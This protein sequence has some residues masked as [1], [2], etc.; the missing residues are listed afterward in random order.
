M[1]TT[2]QPLSFP[3]SGTRLIE[4]SAGTGKTYTIAALY[5]RL[6]LGH[7][8]DHS[9]P[10]GGL[11]PPEILV[12]T[13]TNAATEELRDRIRKRLVEGARCFRGQLAE[14]DPFLTG[15]RDSYPVDAH[16]GCALKLE[17]AAQMMDLSAIHTIHSWC[18]RMLREHAFDSGSLF[19]LELQT[20]L[21]GLRQEAVRDYWR[22][23]FYPM[24]S[25]ALQP[26]YDLYSTPA[27]LEKAL[28]PLLGRGLKGR[29]P[30]EVVEQ[31][32]QAVAHAKTV[33]R[34]EFET[35]SEQI[36]AALAAKLVS[37]AKIKPVLLEEV[38]RWLED[39]RLSLPQTA[40][41][42]PSKACEHFSREGIQAACNKGKSLEPNPAFEAMQGL[43]DTLASLDLKRNLLSHAAA[44]VSDRLE[45]EKQRQAVLGFDD[46]MRHL[47]GALSGDNGPALAQLIRQQFPAALIDEFQDTDPVQYRLFQTLYLDQP[48]CALMMIGDPKQAIYAFRGAD[49]HTYLQARRDT[50]GRH[51]T[52]GTNYRSTA[53]MVAAAN[54][55][56]ELAQGYPQ[57]PFLFADEIPF[58]S[59]EANGKS[60]RLLIDGEEVNGLNLW[61]DPDSEP[62]NK[63]RYLERQAE[64][65]ASEMCRFLT[66]SAQGRAGF[67]RNGTL[68]PLNAADMAILVRDF[69]EAKA[70]RTAL[71]RRGIRS[72]Y[73]SDK[74][75]VYASAE[76][77]DLLLILQAVVAP[78]QERRIRA[79][80]ACLTL[81]MDWATLDRLN[82]DE[83]QWDNLVEQ[84]RGY[85]QHWHNK[86]VLSMVRR[87]MA[88]YGIANRLMH[89]GGGERSLTNLLHLAEL[90][91]A[92]SA[93]VDG[94][95]ALLRLLAE[96]IESGQ[97]DD[98][99]ILRLESDAELVQVVTIH[100][101]KGLEYPLVLLPFVFGFRQAAARDGLLTYRDRDGHNAVAFNPE[102]QAIE[103]AEHERLAEDLR[104]LYVALTRP[105][106]ACFLGLAPVKLGRTGKRDSSDL[107]HSAL[108]YLLG[109][110]EPMDAHDLAARLQELVCPG[111]T[112]L[113][114]LPAVTEMLWQEASVDADTLCARTPKRRVPSGWRV[115]SYSALLHGMSHHRDG[116]DTDAGGAQSRIG[117][118]MAEQDVS[119]PQEP[120]PDSIH[121]FPRGA[122]PGTFLHDWLEWIANQGFDRYS[123]DALSQELQQRCDHKGYESWPPVLQPWV[124]SALAQPMRLPA[125]AEQSQQVALCQLGS[126][127]AEMEFWFA[128][129]DLDVARLDRLVREHLWPGLPRPTL[130][131]QQ[132]HGM[133][134]GFIDLTF[135]H[136]GRFYVADYKSNYLG[137]DDSAYCFEAMQEA[138]LSHRYDLQLALY[139]LALHRLL[140]TRMADYDYQRHLGGGVYLFLRGM[141]AAEADSGN[142]VIALKPDQAL[143]DAM[144][145]L[146]HG[147]TA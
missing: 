77:Q 49:I 22:G 83:H 115:G 112:L 38:R 91:Q 120:E 29:P 70:I 138:M 101:S 139:T 69:T 73:L 93:T 141:G 18:Q 9:H 80:L 39:D 117:E 72:V 114:P 3:L 5:L 66:L 122:G 67:E 65:A 4:A 89:E 102:P 75:S 33:W 92:A 82:G 42:K 113:S 10:S 8:G 118:L 12:V 71:D 145:A 53:G 132:L 2:L 48:H 21:S 109:Q 34:R 41:G 57:G 129:D 58:I 85:Q 94:E 28:M 79:A 68:T 62:V 76:A 144:D 86:G 125:G 142:G 136:Q 27:A 106:Y 140:K 61:L 63:G 32:C 30:A 74:D 56:F 90:M 135:E 44:W 143:V 20:D 88:D 104:L 54:S 43:V 137:P 131:P 17:L 31:Q 1:T 110:G 52:L 59:V 37:K 45:A 96:Q 124:T 121:A 147:E 78:E 13:F 127:V 24:T 133:L 100:K 6:V 64:A 19:S 87:L 23:H 16:P 97:G 108:G 15:L 51:Y 98:D 35:V 14:P 126:V 81:G 46:L 36:H 11:M 128:V 55:V 146:F 103:Q 130:K 84:F 7:G 134:K 40:A 111:Q 107:H 26:I 123:P 50:D 47:D 105:V 116:T 60:D 119:L 25:Q 99:Q 95:L